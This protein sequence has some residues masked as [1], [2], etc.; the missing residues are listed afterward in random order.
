[1]VSGPGGVGKS[2][3]V[4]A[5]VEKYPELWLSRSWTTRERRPSESP[6]A[7]EFVTVDEFEKRM[8]DDG[9]LEYAEFLG[10]YYGTPVLED[11]DGRDVILEID[12]QGARQVVEREPDAV[13]IFLQA[14]SESEQQARLRRRGDPE[15]KV[16]QRVH[17]AAQ[18]A[19]AGRELGAQIITNFDIG[20]TVELMWAVIEKARAATGRTGL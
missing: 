10:N 8:A 18:E 3:V 2:T 19:D 20:E 12:V 15:E 6:K 5:L 4:K 14:P 16:A 1:M 9:F 17:K 11:T 13:L 7:Y